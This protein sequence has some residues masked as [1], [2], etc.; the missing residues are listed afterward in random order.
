GGEE[1]D[2]L[3]GALRILR[4]RG[5]HQCGA[6]GADRFLRAV[7]ERRDVPVQTLDLGIS[8]DGPEARGVHRD[9]ALL[10]GTVG[11]HFRAHV[12]VVDLGGGDLVREVEVVGELE[13][14]DRLRR[15]DV[16]G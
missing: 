12:R 9:Q 2:D 3:E 7:E 8:A 4:G 16:R 13:R 14:L 6:E 1:L 10:E 11:P 5:Y 15:V